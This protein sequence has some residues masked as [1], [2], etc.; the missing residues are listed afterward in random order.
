MTTAVLKASWATEAASRHN[1]TLIRG[2]LLASTPSGS[3]SLE[4]VPASAT[5]HHHLYARGECGIFVA[6]GWGY[7]QG[8]TMKNMV[9]SWY[10]SQD[11]LWRLSFAEEDEQKPWW[12]FWRS[13]KEGEFLG[14]VIVQAPD[15]HEAV[16]VA[17]RR[18][19]NPGGEVFG[20]QILNAD[21]DD[22]NRLL[23]A[24]EAQEIADRTKVLDVERL[25]DA[26]DAGPSGSYRREPVPQRRSSRPPAHSPRQNLKRDP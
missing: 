11:P 25:R 26:R 20:V 3:N 1:G 15:I 10:S 16:Q 4:R 8:S 2:R 13:S 21:L 6:N 9:G 19:I 24:L 18:K 22:L 14:V 5:I 7:L 23:D 17:W 12:K